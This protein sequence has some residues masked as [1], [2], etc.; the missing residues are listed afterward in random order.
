M[1]AYRRQY[2]SRIRGLNH[3]NLNAAKRVKMQAF[4]YCMPTR[5]VLEQ[6]AIERVGE[7][8]PKVGSAIVVTGHSFARRAGLCDRLEGILRKAGV[9]EIAFAPASP[10]P[11]VSEVEA[12]G[13]LARERK[14]ELMIGLGGGS[15]MDAAK[16]AAVVATNDKPLLE[17]FPMHRFQRAPLPLLCIPTTAGTGSETT[18]YAI[19]NNDEGTDKLN[20]NSP[21]TFPIL[22]L[23]DPELSV[24]MPEDITADTGI[25]ALTHAI[26]GYISR[27]SQPL[28]DCLALESIGVI[29]RNLHRAVENGN[30][31][32]ARAAMLY[33][34]AVA[35]IVIAQTGTTVLHALGYYLTLRYGV[36]HGRAN[37]AL[38]GRYLKF[39][40][41]V[42]PEK[43]NNVYSIFGARKEGYRAFSGFVESLG[44]PTQLRSYG[45]KDDDLDAYRDYVMANRS[46]PR[47]PGSVTVED[48]EQ[49]LSDTLG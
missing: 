48:V 23:L 38:L 40:E 12:I 42:S 3:Q 19:I 28:S 34:A 30:D 8:I 31:L 4:S 25:D 17:L 32:D 24:T 1:G 39:I 46:I 36:P 49:L 11:P 6:G 47:T 44:I 33:A 37:G 35:G 10:N 29:R 7:L 9:R 43:I 41:E 15:A 20:L 26:E 22:A 2:N 5:I 16:A 21:R 45:V 27:R 13:R 18:Q 14:A